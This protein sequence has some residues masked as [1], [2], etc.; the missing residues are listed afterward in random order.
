MARTGWIMVA[1]LLGGL[2]A[3]FGLAPAA[4]ATDFERD[5]VNYSASTPDNPVSRLQ[6]RLDAG[7]VKLTYDER[8]GYLRSVLEQLGVPVSSQMLVFS[9][10]SLQRER[11]RPA[12]PRAL[13]FND[14]VY[15][16][17]CQGGTVVELSVVDPKLGAVFYT[18]DQ[19]ATDRPKF[20][21]QTDT[22]LICHGSS[23]TQG[24][25][26]HVVRSV[27]ADGE[28]FPILSSGSYRTDQTSPLK[29]RWGGWYVTGKS[30]PQRH[31]GNLV[32][33]GRQAP[34]YVDNSA[35]VNVTDLG[36]LVKVDPYLAPTSDLVALMVLEHQ[37]DMHNLITRAN[38]LTRAALHEEAEINKALGRP[39]DY[40]SDSTLSRIRSAGEPL[41]KYLLFSD[42]AKL[43]HKLE[44][45]SA[46]A[47]EFTARGPRDDKGRSLRDLDLQTRMFKYPCSYLIYSEPFDT[48]PA[49][50]KDYVY[51]RLGEVLTGKDATPAFAHLTAA[52]R[53]AVLEILRATKP[54][55]PAAL[56]GTP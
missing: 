46:F 54:N 3:V 37:A 24:V 49:P 7:E 29:Q 47:R 15:I 27:Y 26:G 56:A 43:E 1:G 55:L 31:L 36:R 4:R 21:R 51:R 16:G 12:T 30:G 39:A 20:T 28:G 22:C 6:K 53:P 35:G 41:V 40:R 25:P 5:P 9:K 8:V 2:G 38:F 50:V 42:E 13:Y 32:L 11:I 17:F 19:E 14:D 23:Q 18:L 10:T 48:L 52:D 33:R 34:E 44:G 45:V